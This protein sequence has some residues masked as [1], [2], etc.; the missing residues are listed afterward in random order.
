MTSPRLQFFSDNIRPKVDV[1]AQRD[2]R[3]L[4]ETVL[5]ETQTFIARIRDYAAYS[6]SMEKELN[7]FADL[8][9]DVAMHDASVSKEYWMG[10]IESIGG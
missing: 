2:E 10:K 1:F 4:M 7:E 5:K 3:A 8:I 6:E 9:H